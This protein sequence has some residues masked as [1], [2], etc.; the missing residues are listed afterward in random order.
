MA[1]SLRRR[2]KNA[3]EIAKA[4]KA[5]RATKASSASSKKIILGKVPQQDWE[6][7]ATESPV[8]LRYKPTMMLLQHVNDEWKNIM[9][10]L[11]RARKQN[12]NTTI[13]GN[14]FYAQEEGTERLF[15]IQS[16]R[17]LDPGRTVLVEWALRKKSKAMMDAEQKEEEEAEAKENRR[18]KKAPVN[19]E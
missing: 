7:D 12:L 3:G 15:K 18:K 19:K 4:P 16:F 6:Y 5:R 11:G 9:Q 1:P 2:V 14:N 10:D 17:I 8:Y 13:V